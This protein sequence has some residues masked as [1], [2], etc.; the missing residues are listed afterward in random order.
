M[1]VVRVNCAALVFS[2]PFG[3]AI[4]SDSPQTAIFN[5]AVRH[6]PPRRAVLFEAIHFRRGNTPLG[7]NAP[8]SFNPLKPRGLILFGMPQKGC[9]KRI[10][11]GYAP[12]AIPPYLSF[13][14]Q[15][16][17]DN[18]APRRAGRTPPLGRDAQRLL[19]AAST[20]KQSRATDPVDF[21]RNQNRNLQPTALSDRATDATPHGGRCRSAL[22]SW[23]LLSNMQ[24]LP[25][26]RAGS[27][28]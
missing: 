7:Q 21:R 11:G 27:A 26:S 2:S 24:E 12:L 19:L 16:I 18:R 6:H 20:P 28:K 23:S 15:R 10:Q 13:G 14:S 3:R 4:H 1:S 9:K 22:E 8:L 25:S 17:A 5:R